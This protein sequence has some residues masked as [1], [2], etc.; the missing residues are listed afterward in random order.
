MTVQGKNVQITT[1][2][3]AVSAIDT[4]TTLIAGPTQ[5]VRSIWAAVPGSQALSGNMEGYY[6]FR[7][8][9]LSPSLSIEDADLPLFESLRYGS[10]SVPFVW[11]EF[12]VDQYRGHEFRASHFWR[13]PVRGR[14]I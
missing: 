5:D 2:T 11:G 6:G 14:D 10:T 8:P 4:G 13:R 12:L 7:K 9:F 1:G 3:T